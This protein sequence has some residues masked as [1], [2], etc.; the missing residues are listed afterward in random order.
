MA[1]ARR[2]PVF[3]ADI[4]RLGGVVSVHTARDRCGG[5]PTFRVGYI[6]GGGDLA[7][8]S[9][10]IAL[11]DHANAAARVL[12]ELVGGKTLEIEA[13]ALPRLADEYDAAQDRGEIAK[14]GDNLPRIT[15][16]NSKP[17]AADI[18]LSNKDIH[19]ARIIRDAERATREMQIANPRP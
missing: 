2:N 6:S 4:R 12:A 7:F 3:A 15:K 14:N 11:E 5:D 10:P 19:E 1:Q 17:T 9:L 13:Q 16:Q 18:G 8:S